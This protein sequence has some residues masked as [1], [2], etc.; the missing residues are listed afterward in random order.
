LSDA[1]D[2]ITC[3][4]LVELVSDYLEGALDAPDLSRFEAHLQICEDCRTYIDQVRQVSGV[5]A[6]VREDSLEPDLRDALLETF[7]D[8][9][10]ETSL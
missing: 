5:A 7:R 2:D 8:W 9:K 1:L 4:E 3:R 6:R 10:R